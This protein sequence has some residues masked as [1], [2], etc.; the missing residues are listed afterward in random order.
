MRAEAEIKIRPY[1]TVVLSTWVGDDFSRDVLSYRFGFPKPA[2]IK[3]SEKISIADVPDPYK[4]G[5]K[6]NPKNKRWFRRFF[7][8]YS[9]FWNP[10][11]ESMRGFLVDFSDDS[12]KETHPD[13]ASIQET[14]YWTI[15]R[16]SELK[17]NKILLL[18]YPV[19]FKSEVVMNERSIILDAARLFGVPVV[20]TLSA[21]QSQEP[22]RVWVNGNGHHTGAGNDIVCNELVLQGLKGG[23]FHLSR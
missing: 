10:L 12:L 9:I 21:L 23:L 3:V 1:S 20:D 16:F 18:Q 11:I 19:N 17:E 8:E 2:I 22:T 6:Y 4:A 14:I 5:T 7:F 15:K 13:A